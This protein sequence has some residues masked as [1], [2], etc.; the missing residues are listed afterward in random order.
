MESAVE[1]S[2]DEKFIQELRQIVL[3][4][5]GNDQFSVE[6]LARI[7]G[8]SRSQ[9]YRKLKQ[10]EGLSVS[11]F[12]RETRLK[13]AMKLL[14]KDVA[15]VSEIAYRVG[16]NS[17]SYFNTCFHEYFGYPPGEI[18]KRSKYLEDTVASI[19]VHGTRKEP[20]GLNKMKS[21]AILPLEHL[22]ANADLG[23]LT[24]GIH[25]ALIGELGALNDLRVISRTSTLKYASSSLKIQ[26]IARELDVDFI[27]EGS[28]FISNDDLRL[29]LQLIQ[30]F[31]QEQHLWAQVY[32][33]QVSN[34]LSLQSKAIRDIAETIQI[35]LTVEQQQRLSKSKKVD[36]ETHKAYLRGIYYLNKSTPE[37][38][39]KG[40]EY[41]QQ[42]IDRDPADPYAYA[43]LAEGYITLG[44]GPDPVST[45]WMKA[46]AL[47]Q[48][49]VELDP[50]MAKAHAVLAM[51]RLYFEGDWDGADLAFKRANSINPNIAFS[52]FHQ[53]WFHV[54]FGRK[55]KALEEGKLAKQLDPL[56]PIIT[57]DL[58]SVYYFFGDYDKAIVEIEQ[59]LE[60][61]K[62]FGHSWYLFGQVYL[63]QGL[64]NKAIEA[65]QKAVKIN[66]I[67][68]FALANSYVR[69]GQKS[70]GLA[71]LSEL[72]RNDITSRIA[73]GLT[74]IYVS[75]GELEE[76]FCWLDYQPSDFWVPWIRTFPGFESLRNDPRFEVFLKKRNLPPVS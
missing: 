73:F 24:V 5:L 26:E 38:F 32:Y 20:A 56:T 68:K 17:T 59:A 72:K 31:P 54:L 14:K 50:T 23:Y 41:F 62:N 49:A 11:Q 63:E 13:E 60:L 29:Q 52:R 21:M 66:Q 57:A 44:H 47:A 35:H 27:V 45:H 37:D 39:Q 33:Q 6:S 4:N 76:A 64:F 19:R 46:K 48:R 34:I 22:S 28:V 3:A 15:N 25:D 70:Q 30:A 2:Q 55:D 58:G 61:D 43:G 69:A 42:A 12:I 71:I 36:P 18:K 53:S 9:L 8:I 67:W 51:V 1:Y 7:K 65:H 10:C 40:L 75:L 74:Q 16:F